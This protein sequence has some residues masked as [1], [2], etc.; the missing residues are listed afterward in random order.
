MHLKRKCR[1]RAAKQPEGDGSDS[2]P[3]SARLHSPDPELEIVIRM[4]SFCGG[5]V[6]CL[7]NPKDGS[8]RPVR[9]AWGVPAT[10]TWSVLGCRPLGCGVLR[11]GFPEGASGRVLIS[12]VVSDR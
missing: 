6:L 9:V 11:F 4:A 5:R 10:V 8:R 12:V 2:R 1:G 7:G 3:G